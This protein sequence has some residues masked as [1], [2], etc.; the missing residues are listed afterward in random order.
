MK[1]KILEKNKRLKKLIIDCYNLPE[2]SNDDMENQDTKKEIDRIL[3][4]V[5][6]LKF[7]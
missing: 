1:N 4:E 5:N 7:F 2:P 3:I 6:K